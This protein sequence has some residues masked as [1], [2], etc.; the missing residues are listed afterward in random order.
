MRLLLTKNLCAA[1]VLTSMRS[2]LPVG[3]LAHGSNFPRSSYQCRNKATGNSLIDLTGRDSGT[4][5]HTINSTHES[6]TGRN[7]ESVR[8]PY[9]M[10]K[11]VSTLQKMNV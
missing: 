7:L 3:A 5:S 4:A 10:S 2:A 8:M 9:L 6:T 11:W 1:P